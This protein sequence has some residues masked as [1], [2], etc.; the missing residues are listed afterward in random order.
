[1]GTQTKAFPMHALVFISISAIN[2]FSD[3]AWIFQGVLIW[4]PC[5]YLALFLLKSLFIYLMLLF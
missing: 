5:L 2:C 1:M 3:I 4:I